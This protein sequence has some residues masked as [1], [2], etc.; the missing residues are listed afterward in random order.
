MNMDGSAIMQGCATVFIAHLY[1]I[2]LS[3][4]DYVV[5][6]GIAVLASIGTAAVPKAGLIM[7]TM[8]FNQVGLPVEAI[9]II[10]GIDHFLDMTRTAINV[11]GDAV[12]TTVVAKSEGKIDLETFNDPEAGL[13]DDHPI[14][15]N[16]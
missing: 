3:L 9:G 14:E 2:D 7:L 6:V 12:V 11:T 16:L 5:V 10:I 4:V 13:I 15:H 8:V 1:G